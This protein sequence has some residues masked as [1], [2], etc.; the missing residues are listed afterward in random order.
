MKEKAN[1]EKVMVGLSGGVDSSV[2]ALLLKESGYRVE[3]VT[4]ISS[5]RKGSSK[6]DLFCNLDMAKVVADKLG[7]EHFTLDVS[8][9]FLTHV[10]DPFV[11]SYAAGKTPNPCARCNRYI[12]FDL[13]LNEALSRGFDYIA[14]GHHVRRKQKNGEYFLYKGRDENKDQSYFLYSLGQRELANSLFPVGQIKKDQIYE[15]AEKNDLPSAGL[16]ESQDLCFV[17][18]GG[19]GSYV[20]KKS[21]EPVPSGKI[22]DTGGNIL[23]SHSGLPHYTIGQRRGLGLEMNEARYVVEM[24]PEENVIVVGDEEELYSKGLIASDLSWVSGKVPQGEL[25]V[26]IKV[27][28]RSKAVSGRVIPKNNSVEVLFDFPVKAV[29]PGQKAVFYRHSRVVGGGTIEKSLE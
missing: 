1:K 14:T 13:V 27:R 23:G 19:I 12:R 6:D 25:R 18:E 26:D 24:L 2:A 29:T 20:D 16:N 22:I 4:F 11:E 5:N 10:V 8:E 21:D 9:E 7:I 15:L 17:T 28:Y 3:G